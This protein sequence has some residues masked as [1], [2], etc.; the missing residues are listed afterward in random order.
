MKT[1]F[2]IVATALAMIFSA[3]AAT[4]TIQT[5]GNDGP[6]ILDGAQFFSSGSFVGNTRVYAKIDLGEVD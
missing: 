6:K 5:G 2:T 3:N 4:L 1:R